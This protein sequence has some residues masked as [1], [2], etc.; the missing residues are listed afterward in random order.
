MSPIVELLCMGF[1]KKILMG[2]H[3]FALHAIIT[4]ISQIK[5]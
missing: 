2:N 3:Y 1:I 5:K 4:I